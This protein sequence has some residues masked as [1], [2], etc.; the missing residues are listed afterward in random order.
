VI[1]PFLAGAAAARVASLRVVP[2]G[3]DAIGALYRGDI[4]LA[5]S[6]RADV[7]GLADL[8]V[9]PLVEDDHALVVRRGHPLARGRCSIDAYLAGEHVA[10]ETAAPGLSAVERALSALGRSRR[11]RARVPSLLGALS[12]AAETD[13]VASLPSAAARASGLRLAIRT[14]PFAVERLSL[15]LVFHPRWVDDP[16]HRQVRRALVEAAGGVDPR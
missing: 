16:H 8:V 4:D 2:L 15:K 7:E 5:L 3:L 1:R 9:R 14:L 11:V 12:L 13:L 10:I 6:P